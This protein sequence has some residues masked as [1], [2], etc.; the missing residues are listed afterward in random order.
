MLLY[1]CFFSQVSP[2]DNPALDFVIDKVPQI[3]YKSKG[4]YQF[5]TWKD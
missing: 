1:R 2:D 4:W 5:N 3:L